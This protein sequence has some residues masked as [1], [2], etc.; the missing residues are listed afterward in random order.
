MLALIFATLTATAATPSPQPAPH[1]KVIANVRSD[2]LCSSMHDTMVPIAYV[3][4]RNEEAFAALNHSMLKFLQQ[5]PGLKFSTISQMSSLDAALDQAELYNPDAEM[6]VQQMNGITY[7]MAQNLTL[8]GQVMSASWKQYPK[9]KFPNVDAFRQRLQN[10][11][12]LQRALEEKYYQFSQMY[13]DNR[14]QGK[15]TP[16]VPVFESFLHDTLAGYGSALSEA[17][18]QSDPEIPPQ[19]DAGGIAHYGNI[20]QVVRELHLQELAFASEFVT[21]G[22]TCGLLPAATPSPSK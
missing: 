16:S 10:L 12:D 20:A 13:L 19:A 22:R 18:T 1:L 2:S 4:H 14:D 15:Y 7:Q 3:T 11:I 5:V 6:S 8:E 21:A 17:Q 9:G